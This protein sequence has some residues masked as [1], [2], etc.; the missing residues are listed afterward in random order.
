MRGSSHMSWAGVLGRSDGWQ[1]R[2]AVVAVPIAVVKKFIED[3][4]AGLGVSGGL[5]GVLLGLS[6]LLAFVSH[7]W[8]RVPERSLFPEAGSRLDVTADAGDRVAD[9]R[10]HRVVCQQRGAGGRARGRGVERT[11]RHPGDRQRARSPLGRATAG[12]TRVREIE[13]AADCS[14]S[15]PWSHHGRC[16][17]DGR[18]RQR[19]RDHTGDPKGARHRSGGRH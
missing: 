18:A 12:S 15:A 3:D 13:A 6:L 11:R 9:Q 7:S 16:H 17:R 10:S 2:H 8:F 14:Y 5:L 4:A 19:G 1:A